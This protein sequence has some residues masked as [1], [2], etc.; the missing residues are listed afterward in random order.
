MWSYH[1]WHSADAELLR[2]ID[3]ALDLADRFL[4]DFNSLAHNFA[5]LVE[6]LTKPPP[7][8]MTPAEE[9]E[10]ARQIREEADKLKAA[11]KT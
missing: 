11:S 2:R 1:Y 10:V 4:D 5:V 6:F 3:R 9:A 8:G 7:P